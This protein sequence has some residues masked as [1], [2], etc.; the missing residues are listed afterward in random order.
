MFTIFTVGFYL[1]NI[2][3]ANVDAHLYDFD[4]SD[5]LSL[6]ISPS[7]QQIPMAGPVPGVKL[8]ITF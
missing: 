1:L 3:D 2:V 5:D 8:R 4:I 6:Q 7:A